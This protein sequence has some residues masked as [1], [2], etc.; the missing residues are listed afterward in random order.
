MK[1]ATRARLCRLEEEL[2]DRDD[3]L[4]LQFIR[5]TPVM[6]GSKEHLAALNDPTRHDGLIVIF[7]DEPGPERAIL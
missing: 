3:E 6:E 2:R 5:E 4:G 1:A 7:A